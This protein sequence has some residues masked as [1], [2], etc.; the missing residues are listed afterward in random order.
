MGSKFSLTSAA[1]RLA[2]RGDRYGSVRSPISD[3]KGSTFIPVVVDNFGRW[4]DLTSLRQAEAIN[5]LK[6]SGH[7]NVVCHD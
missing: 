7:L 3:K 5:I 1:E 4:V 2:W 6:K